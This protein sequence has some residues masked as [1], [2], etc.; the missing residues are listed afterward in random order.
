MTISPFNIIHIMILKVKLIELI[1][2]T[3]LLIV[4]GR[5]EGEKVEVFRK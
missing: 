3:S 1:L 4:L 2:Q 5:N